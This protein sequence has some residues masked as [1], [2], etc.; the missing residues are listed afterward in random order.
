V[1]AYNN[2]TDTLNALQTLKPDLAIVDIKMPGK[3]GL[4]VLK[5]ARE[6]NNSTKFIVLTLHA[7]DIYRQLA[8]ENGADYFFSKADDFEKIEVVVNEMLSIELN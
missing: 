2:G 6:K 1:G 4:D 8:M 3:S 5:E 7:T